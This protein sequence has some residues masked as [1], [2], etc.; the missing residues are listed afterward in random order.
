[1]KAWTGR[2]KADVTRLLAWWQ[3]SRPGRALAR[4]GRANGPLLCGGIAYAAIFSLFAGL[5]IG[6]T[7]FMAVLGSDE[8]L[9]DSVVDTIDRNLPG[10]LDV[11]DGQGI[12]SPD[13]LVLSTS[14]SWTGVIAAGVLLWSAMSCMGAIRSSVQAMFGVVVAPDSAVLGKLRELAGFVGVGFAVLASAVVGVVVNAASRWLLDWMG[15]TGSSRVL[16]PG[17]GF[18]GSFAVDV[19]V[20]VMVVVVLAGQRPRRRD[21]LAGAALAAAALGVVRV[22]GTSVV[23]GSTGSNPLLA[24]FAVIVTL[25]VWINLFA[26]IILIAAAF[27]ANPPHLPELSE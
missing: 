21:L 7:A 2:R 10:L 16:V 22:L 14:L 20:F 13:S 9:R 8:T 27:T 25:L 19:G 26:R 12:V 24:S 6:Y 1:M 17:L 15:L 11:G 4:Y 18:L 23:A 5:T 3:R